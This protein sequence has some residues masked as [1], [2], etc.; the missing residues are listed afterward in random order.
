V[1]NH[2]AIAERR[3]LEWRHDPRKWQLEAFERERVPLSFR[4][5]TELGEHKLSK[6][7]DNYNGKFSV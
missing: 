4:F 2:I 6:T 5:K 7:L 1:Q 3:N